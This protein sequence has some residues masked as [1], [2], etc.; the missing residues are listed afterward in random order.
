VAG[1]CSLAVVNLKFLAVMGLGSAGKRRRAGGECFAGVL[2][3][4]EEAGND[5]MGCPFG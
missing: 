1:A 5:A 4:S 3:S 2:D